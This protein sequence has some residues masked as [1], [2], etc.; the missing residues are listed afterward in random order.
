MVQVKA[1]VCAWP[2]VWLCQGAGVTWRRGRA[3][4]VEHNDANVVCFGERLIGP[5]VA[6]EALDA[7]LGAA[8]AGGRHQR[9]VD[10]LMAIEAE[11]AG[12]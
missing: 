10:M 8:F 11:E 4:A 1:D 6:K 5:G 3:L 7:F 2:V 9:R 12:R